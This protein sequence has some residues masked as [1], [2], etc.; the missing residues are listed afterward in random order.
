MICRIWY[1]F[2]RTN[3]NL[4]S[5]PTW[6]EPIDQVD[7]SQDS[8][9]YFDQ[10]GYDLT[11]LEEHYAFANGSFVR[12][13]RWRRAIY[14]DWFNCDSTQGL[15]LNHASLFER[16]GYHGL[17]QEQIKNFAQQVPIVYKLIHMK[18]KWGIDISIDY[19]DEHKAFEVFHYEWDD[20]DYN[21]VLAKQAEIENVVVNTNWPHLAQLLWQRRDRW[22]HLDFD[23]QTRYKTDYLGLEPE[24]FKLVTWT[25]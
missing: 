11:P 1:M 4:D 24:R 16:K 2:Y 8:M 17:A 15:H 20:F 23:G 9:R 12:N 5:T 13:M 3:Y 25:L 14:K 18:P 7:I 21:R 19:V 22:M 10:N 6:G